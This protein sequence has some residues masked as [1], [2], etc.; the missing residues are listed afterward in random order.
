MSSALTLTPTHTHPLP[1][2]SVQMYVGSLDDSGCAAKPGLFVTRQ[3]ADGQV[4]FWL[5]EADP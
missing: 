4:Y 2:I 5:S 1:V 3:A